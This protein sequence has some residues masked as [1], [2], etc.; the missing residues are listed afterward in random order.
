MPILK[1]N[2]K[3]LLCYSLLI[4]EYELTVSQYLDI[5][6]NNLSSEFSQSKKMVKFSVK[7]KTKIS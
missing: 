6:K 3:K 4:F 7:D 1:P 2:K 5:K